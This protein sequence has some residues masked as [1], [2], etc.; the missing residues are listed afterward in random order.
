M[1]VGF[2]QFSAE[3]KEREKQFKALD[4]LR[5]E[6]IETKDK[7]KK[8]KEKR[9]NRIEERKRLIR[10]KKALRQ[11]AQAESFLNSLL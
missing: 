7:L 11:E 8:A 3:D 2:Y 4:D 1:G 6:T 5:Q 10:E 9:Q